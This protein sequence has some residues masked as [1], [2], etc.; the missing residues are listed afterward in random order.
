VIR[1]V[2]AQACVRERTGE[3]L[4]KAA[5]FFGWPESPFGCGG[6]LVSKEAAPML[7]DPRFLFA[8]MDEFLDA[9]EVR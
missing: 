2:V 6:Y 1:R 8:A 5:S 7:D 4:A 9:R 3:Q